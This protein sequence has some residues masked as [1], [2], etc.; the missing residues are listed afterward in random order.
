[1]LFLDSFAFYGKLLK[2]SVEIMHEVEQLLK[3]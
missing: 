1:M 3:M 2:L